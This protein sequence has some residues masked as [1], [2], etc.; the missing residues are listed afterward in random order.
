MVDASP[1]QQQQQQQ[2]KKRKDFFKPKLV[3]L[4]NSQN[5]CPGTQTVK[6]GWELKKECNEPLSACKVESCTVHEETIFLF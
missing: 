2:Q 6:I 3:G 4:D 1:Q 5:L